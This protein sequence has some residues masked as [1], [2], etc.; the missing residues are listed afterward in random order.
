MLLVG[1]VLD[2]WWTFCCL[3]YVSC[4]FCFCCI[5][6]TFVL[7]LIAWLVVSFGLR[8]RDCMWRFIGVCVCVADTL[9][10]VWGG[11]GIMLLVVSGSLLF[12]CFR[13]FWF[14]VIL[15]FW[16]FFF[17]GLVFR[18]KSLFRHL[19]GLFVCLGLCFERFIGLM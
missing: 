18:V 5:L 10:T 13:G 8:L 9:F 11:E 16:V 15:V 19:Y 2:D 4:T 14:P 6:V 12:A 1:G 17:L 3:I 7:G